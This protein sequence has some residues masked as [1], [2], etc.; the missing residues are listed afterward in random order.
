MTLCAGHVLGWVVTLCTYIFSLS[1]FFFFF[2]VSRLAWFKAK[3]CQGLE[4]ALFV[5]NGY[6]LSNSIFVNLGGYLFLFDI[7]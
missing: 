1:F 3:S 2:L 6:N 5:E 4:F 7:L